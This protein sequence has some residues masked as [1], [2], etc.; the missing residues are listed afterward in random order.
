MC[1]L[2]YV[3][4]N[5]YSGQLTHVCVAQKQQKHAKWRVQP[6]QYHDKCAVISEHTMATGENTFSSG[7]RG[8]SQGYS[9]VTSDIIDVAEDALS[10]KESE[11]D[12]SDIEDGLVIVPQSTLTQVLLST[13]VSCIFVI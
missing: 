13:M 9:A 1:I 7:I 10:E 5:V 11:R 2:R 8:G 4:Q 3:T 6:F 12:G